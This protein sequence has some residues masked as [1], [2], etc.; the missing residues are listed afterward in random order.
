[1]GR[2]AC[3]EEAFGFYCTTV[4]LMFTG[5]Y[6]SPNVSPRVFVSLFR[7][8]FYMLV[9]RARYAMLLLLGAYIRCEALRHTQNEVLVLRSQQCAL[10]LLGY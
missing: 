3:P 8:L 2:C 5:E 6:V 10:V 4:S 1:M 9:L 7:L